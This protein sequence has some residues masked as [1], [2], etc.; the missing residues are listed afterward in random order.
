MAGH[1]D[2]DIF[3]NDSGVLKVWTGGGVGS[4]KAV[5]PANATAATTATSATTAGTVTT[6]AQPN[7]TSLGT[8]TALTVDSI[9]LNGAAITSSSGAISFSN[10][11]ISTTGTLES[12]VQTSTGKMYSLQSAGTSGSYC[13]QGEATSTSY[14][15]TMIRLDCN[16]TGASS[17]YFEYYTSGNNADIE[18]TVKGNGDYTYDG[19][20]ASPASDFAEYLE[21]SDGNPDDEDRS[22]LTVTIVPTD[23]KIMIRPAVDGDVVYGAVSRRPTIVGGSDFNHWTG[24][25]LKDKYGRYL[26]D[27]NGNKMLNPDFDD[28]MEHLPREL[29]PEWDSIGITGILVINDGQPTDPRWCNFGSCGESV[30]RWLIR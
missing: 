9:T 28:T 4:W 14:A 11:N 2:G 17:W 16:S 1:G 7:I 12:G 10:E 15:T 23:N 24:K 3:F 20:G 8:L 30:S 27:A 19:S 25:Y 5:V 26:F 22:G 18:W 13:F 29:R 6:A 21:W